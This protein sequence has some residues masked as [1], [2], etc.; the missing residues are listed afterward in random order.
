M[1]EVPFTTLYSL[2]LKQEKGCGRSPREPAQLCQFS[3]REKA[4][5]I[6]INKTVL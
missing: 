5:V 1:R 6:Q 2:C 3:G 4:L